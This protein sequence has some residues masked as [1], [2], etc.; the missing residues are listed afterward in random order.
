[1][2]NLP[3]NIYCSQINLEGICIYTL[4]ISVFACIP[5]KLEICN[6]ALRKP[7]FVCIPLWP[8]SHYKF[9]EEL[10]KLNNAKEITIITII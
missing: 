7:I 1:M 3:I 4:K 6:Y 2:C 5:L 8:T 10:L 9:D